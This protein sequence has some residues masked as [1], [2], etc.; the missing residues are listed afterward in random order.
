MLMTHREN[1]EM[2]TPEIERTRERDRELT[3]EIVI[4]EEDLRRARQAG[5]QEEIESKQE[6]LDSLLRERNRAAAS[7]AYWRDRRPLDEKDKII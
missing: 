7:H 4:A 3:R 5:I 6:Y 2:N 1:F